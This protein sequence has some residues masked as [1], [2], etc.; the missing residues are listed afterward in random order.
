MNRYGGIIEVLRSNTQ[1]QVDVVQG[2]RTGYE[3]PVLS[4]IPW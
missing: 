1:S 4:R 2:T 3:V